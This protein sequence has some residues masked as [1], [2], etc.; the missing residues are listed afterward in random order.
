MVLFKQGN[1]STKDYKKM[2]KKIGIKHDA[3]NIKFFK[4][5]NKKNIY[6]SNF[7]LLG[8]LN[9]DEKLS[10]HNILITKEG[11]YVK[12]LD[13]K[14]DDIKNEL[15]ILLYLKED[16]VNVNNMKKINPDEIIENKK[17]NLLE[18]GNVDIKKSEIK[19]IKEFSKEIVR[20]FEN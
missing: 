14:L 9:F 16:I 15:K 4:I 2:L 3:D 10:Y 6:F 7:L 1:I 17:C 18:S 8:I 13:N 19:K 12:T 5:V 11:K 20:K